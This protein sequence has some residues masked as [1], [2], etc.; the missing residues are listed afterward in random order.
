MDGRGE[1]ILRSSFFEVQ[2]TISIISVFHGAIP[3]VG[4][5]GAGGSWTVEF[6]FL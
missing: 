4:V 2:R 1:K 5:T 6:D 3:D